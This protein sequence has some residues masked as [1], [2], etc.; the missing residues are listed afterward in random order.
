MDLFGPF[1]SVKTAIKKTDHFELIDSFQNLNQINEFIR[2]LPDTEI[3]PEAAIYNYEIRFEENVGFV[4]ISAKGSD[5][6][7][8]KSNSFTVP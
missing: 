6:E 4:E 8:V 1:C 5:A 3:N 7:K 2:A